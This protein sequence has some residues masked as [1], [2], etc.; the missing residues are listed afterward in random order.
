MKWTV[1]I[2]CAGLALVAFA[3]QSTKQ[4]PVKALMKAK[5]GYAHRLLDAVVAQDFDAVREQAFRLKAVAETADWNVLATA[6]YARE[7]EDFIDATEGLLDSAKARN[8]DAVALAYMDVT[9]SCIHC[10]RYI[11]ANLKP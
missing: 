7:S 6:E 11:K 8:G 4:D 5:T 1:A 3:F 2:A 9:L 10:H